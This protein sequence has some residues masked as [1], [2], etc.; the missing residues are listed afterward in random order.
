MTEVKP[1]LTGTPDNFIQHNGGLPADFL[2]NHPFYDDFWREKAAKLEQITVPMLVCASFSDHGL[3]TVGSFR[4]F[5]E[6]ASTHKWVYTHRTG[7]WDVYYSKEVQQLTK[8]FMDCFLKDDTTNGFMQRPPVRLE[9]RSSRDGIHQIRHEK[10]WPLQRTQYQRL[11]LDAQTHALTLHKPLQYG[12]VIHSARKGRSSFTLRFDEDTE[13]SGYM[14]L[15]LWVEVRADDARGSATIP[16]DMAMFVA[17]NKLDKS[18]K[19]VH[20]YGS[21]GNKEDMVTR[22][23]CR[24]SRRELDSAKSTEWQPVLSGASHQPLQA[25]E[26]VAVDIE[27]YPSSTFFASGETLQL[28]VASDEIIPSPPYRKNT[29]YNKG[30]HVIHSGAEYDSYLLV[31]VI[32]A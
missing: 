32:P 13:L 23:F 19:T 14:K 9:V 16:D 27:L 12:E 21:V 2:K 7:K 20:F 5:I 17:I 28:I 3:H 25:G 24:V 1:A 29:S 22:G 4:A 15:R 8:E 26:I 6:A 11:F 18:G 10:E 30:T 31:P